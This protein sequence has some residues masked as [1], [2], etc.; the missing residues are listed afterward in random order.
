MKVKNGDLLKI[1]LEDDEV[2]YGEKVGDF[3]GK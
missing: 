2:G 3:G 1:K